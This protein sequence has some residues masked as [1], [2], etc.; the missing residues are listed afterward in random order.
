MKSRL[1]SLRKVRFL[2]DLRE[3]LGL[4][5]T[6]LALEI[7]KTR[8]DRSASVSRSFICAIQRNERDLLPEQMTAL[9]LLVLADLRD[10]LRRDDLHVRVTHHSTWHVKVLAPCVGC[11]KPFELQRTTAKRCARCVAK[12]RGAT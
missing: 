3:W 7:P 12:R 2:R 10:E 4:S 5:I 6:Q 1:S 9:T 8:G 11:G